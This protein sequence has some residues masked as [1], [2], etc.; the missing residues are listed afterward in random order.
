M[1]SIAQAVGG[2]MSS[3]AQLQQAK[4]QAGVSGQNAVLAGAGADQA[5][6]AGNTMAG[7]ALTKGSELAGTEKAD[8]A[9]SGV[10]VNAGTPSNVMLSTKAMS[11]IDAA[12]IQNNATRQAW[13]Y[14][15]QE[16]SDIQQAGLDI[17]A[18]ETGSAATMLNTGAEI[19][20]EGVSDLLAYG[21]GG[22]R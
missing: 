14:K 9:A 13:G 5:L 18:G 20:Q 8:Y 1:G 19:G 6:Y 2:V 11:A 21:R 12:T 15:V 22:G 7:R 10:D 17:Y 16:G 4:F 3:N